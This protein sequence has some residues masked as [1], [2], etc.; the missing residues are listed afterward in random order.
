M[1]SLGAVEIDGVTRQSL[2]LRGAI[3]AGATFGLGAVAPFVS[4]ALAAGTTSDIDV[5]NFALTLEYLETSYYLVKGKTVGLSA[6]AAT[7][8]SRFG[9][10]EGRHVEALTK[11]IGEL[12]GK[13]AAMP[14]FNFP[15][16]SEPTFLAL[17]YTLENLGVAAY[18]GAAPHVQSPAIL[19]T[20]GSIVQVE[21]RHAAV[22]GLLVNRP[23]TPD[24]AFD[25][26]LTKSQVLSA[27]GPFI[28]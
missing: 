17:A 12:G 16:A 18:N 8:A 3:A 21:A 15:V 6:E 4:G 24:G 10:E 1:P 11:A 2:I 27:A 9:H 7:Y 28:A 14:R 5:L 19:A 13:P 20:A 22:I 26:P 23:V 25:K